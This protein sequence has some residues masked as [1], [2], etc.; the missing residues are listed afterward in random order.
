MTTL[1]VNDGFLAKD[2]G[3]GLVKLIQYHTLIF[4]I[5]NYI[6]ILDYSSCGLSHEFSGQC[7]H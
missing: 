4:L 7:E 1:I 6:M 2:L 3:A 5:E